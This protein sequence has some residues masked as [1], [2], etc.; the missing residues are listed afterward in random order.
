MPKGRGLR[1]PVVQTR[2]GETPRSPTSVR[3]D[4]RGLLLDRIEWREDYPSLG[5]ALIEG[6]RKAGG[7]SPNHEHLLDVFFSSG[8]PSL[9]SRS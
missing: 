4:P 3:L 8:G 6:Y 1:P 9:A 2:G 7:F 5:A